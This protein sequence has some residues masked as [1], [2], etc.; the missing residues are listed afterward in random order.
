MG[1]GKTTIGKRLA[2]ELG[3]KFIDLD[4]FISGSMGVSISEIVAR[5]GI[6]FFR[7]KEKEALSQIFEMKNV[8]VSTG[9]GT[10]CFFDNMDQIN[11]NGISIY[12]EMD[13]KSLVNRLVKNTESR[14]LIAGKSRSE[15]EVFVSE[16]LG[17]RLE[18]YKR[19][20]LTINALSFKADKLKDLKVQLEL[21]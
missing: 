16:H 14:P 15:L 12:L 13:E 21:I 11:T 10:P 2:K 4:G 8:V 7:E 5:H 17:E 3:V 9:G 1:A 20:Q 18:Y 19:A 6:D